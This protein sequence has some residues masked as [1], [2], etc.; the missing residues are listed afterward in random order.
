MNTRDLI[1]EKAIDLFFEYGYNGASI[2]N[3]V[4]ELG[5]TKASVYNYFNSKD[6]ILY[7]I[8]QETGLLLLQ[9]SR[10]IVEKTVDPIEC[11]EKLIRN[12]IYLIKDSRKKIRIYIEQQYQLPPALREKARNLQ[13]Q[14]YHTHYRAIQKLKDQ[15]ILRDDIDI[16][17]FTYSILGMSNWVFRWFKDDG[18]LSA[19]EVANNL[20]KIA[21]SNFLIP[22]QPQDEVESADSKTRMSA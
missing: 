11:L 6:E 3:I 15:Q 8:I 4:N 22:D 18:R 21:F 13:L 17:V 10:S 9:S 16:T 12:L 20:I 19:E 1:L 5:M 7:T 2:R 14:I